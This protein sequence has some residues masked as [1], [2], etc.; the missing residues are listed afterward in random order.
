MSA[1]K[2]HNSFKIET[3]QLK[4]FDFQ[5]TGKPEQK[6]KVSLNQKIG[7]IAKK[8]NKNKYIEYF[9]QVNTDLSFRQEDSEVF[10]VESIIV[11]IIQTKK[12]FDESLLNNMVAIMYSYLRPMVAQV[13]VMA[14]LQ[15]LDLPPANFENFKVKVEN[16]S[17][18][19]KN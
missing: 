1:V 15:P 5:Q 16:Q 14:K 4:K 12:D 19:N 17:I 8:E 11:S 13:T 2:Q 6:K 3:I 7:A 9:I 10:Y 18:I